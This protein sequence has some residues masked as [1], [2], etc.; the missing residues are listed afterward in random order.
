MGGIALASVAAV[1]YPIFR[2]LSPLPDSGGA[3][4]ISF[5]E[6]NMKVGDVL[7]F[8]HA[9]S[10]AVLMKNRADEYTAFSAVCTHLGCIVQWNKDNREFICP[11]H[12]GRYDSRG[13][14]LAGPPPRPLASIPVK[15]ANGNITVG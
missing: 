13:A 7:Y 2:Y 15:L 11:C 5:P 8:Q 3:S 14:V 12:A 9:G 4:R 6:G 1:G 10:A